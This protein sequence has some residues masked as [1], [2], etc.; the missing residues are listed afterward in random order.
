[1]KAYD[2]EFVATLNK[3]AVI[4]LGSA[5][6]WIPKSQEAEKAGVSLRRNQRWWNYYNCY[7][8]FSMKEKT[9]AGRNLPKK[10]HGYACFLILRFTVEQRFFNI[11]LLFLMEIL[12]SYRFSPV[13]LLCRI[14]CCNFHALKPRIAYQRIGSVKTRLP[15][16][17]SLTHVQALRTLDIF[18]WISWVLPYLVLKEKTLH[19]N[20]LSNLF[21]GKQQFSRLVQA[22]L[23]SAVLVIPFNKTFELNIL[24]LPNANILLLISLFCNIYQIEN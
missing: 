23:K 5:A 17:L 14:Y 10:L 21:W 15:A 3:C 13:E 19:S 16:L 1:M 7:F 22:N 18:S 20:V 12:A 24:R 2:W 9:S 11:L 4:V 6:P 8:L